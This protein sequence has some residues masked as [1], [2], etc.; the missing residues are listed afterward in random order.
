[1]VRPRSVAPAEKKRQRSI[2]A[3]N[4]EWSKINQT[5]K[6]LGFRSMSETLLYAFD[7]Y[8][9]TKELFEELEYQLKDTKIQLEQTIKASLAWKKLYE[10]K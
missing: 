10:E 4:K 9:H 8:L 5:R 1:M 2:C 7:E 6:Y 3:S